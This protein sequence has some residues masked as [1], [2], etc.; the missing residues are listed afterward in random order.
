MSKIISRIIGDKKTIALE[1][2]CLATPFF[3]A[4]MAF[5]S[6]NS[7]T[8][9]LAVTIA[10]SGGGNTSGD[11]GSSATD[12]NYT[13]SEDITESVNNNTDS[14]LDQASYAG[15]YRDPNSGSLD[16]ITNS[17][18]FMSYAY[19]NSVSSLQQWYDPYTGSYVYDVSME[20]GFGLAQSFY[21]EFSSQSADCSNNF[22]P[23]DY[24]DDYNGFPFGDY[25]GSSFGD[26][27]G[28]DDS[29][30]NDENMGSSVNLKSGNLYHAQRVGPLAL[31]Y[32]SL[33]PHN[34]PL[35]TGW[36]H[37]FNLT[38]TANPDGSLILKRKDG[39]T[40]YF[41]QDSSGI[42]HADAK[43]GDTSSI[44]QNPHGSY[45]QTTKYGKVSTF[46][47]MGR[48]TSITDRNGNTTN[49][50]YNGTGLVGITDSTGRTVQFGVANGK[51]FSITDVAGMT[52]TISY[53]GD[54][55]SAIS[56]S[57]G[58]TWHYL[59][60]ANARM[61]RKTDPSGNVTSYTYDSATGMLTAST[62]PYGNVKSISYDTANGMAT[63]TQKDGGIWTR[64]YDPVLGAPLAVTD[65]YGNT[66]TYSYDSLR[67]LLS[68]AFPNGNTKSF[69]YDAAGN[70]TSAADALGNTTTM[71]YNAQNRVTGITDPLGNKR[72]FTYDQV[73]NLVSYTNPAGETT[74][75]QR[76]AKGNITNFTA[77]GNRTTQY[78]YD[79]YNHV[80]GVVDP[81][82]AATR[83]TRD[84][85]GNITG[86]TDA[87]GNTTQLLYD[88]INELVRVIDPLGDATTYTY[89]PNGNRA[90]KTDASGAATYYAY[91][92]NRRLTKLTDAL[93]GVTTFT[94]GSGGC[95]SCGAGA[96]K[97]ISITH[98]NGGVKNFAYDL[99]GRR[100]SKTDAVG[101]ST[102]YTY[103]ANGNPLTLTE[104]DGNTWQFAYDMKN[105]R[106]KA[107]DP[108]GIVTSYTYDAVGNRTS[109]TDG[110]GNVTLFEHNFR[111]QVT[112]I[113]DA[114]GNATT[115]AYGDP[116][117]GGG[118]G[119]L[120]S[121][122][123][124]DGNSIHFYYDLMGR[125][126]KVTDAL[127]NSVSYTYDANGNIISATDANGHTASF[128]HDVLN[129]VSKAVD[130]LKGVVN[131]GYTHTGKL[132]SVTDALGNVT[133]YNRDALGRATGVISPDA[134]TTVYAYN[135]DG[136]IK[137]R[138]DANGTTATFS[139]DLIGRLTG[140]QFPDSSQNISYAYDATG[141]QNGRGHLTGMTDPS[142]TVAFDY[143]KLGRVVNEVKAI[144]GVTYQTSYGYDAA[145]NLT[146]VTYPSGRTVAY[147][148]NAV[149]RP[150]DVAQLGPSGM[151]NL[152]SS[153]SYDKRGNMLN[154]ALGN[155]LTEKRSYDA[156]NLI[157][158]M[159]VPRVMRLNYL[160]D[161][162]KNI[163]AISDLLQAERSK[164]YA[165]DPL[166]RLASARGP[167]GIE[168]FA[169]DANGNRLSENINDASYA[170]SY[171]RNRLSGVSAERYVQ[172]Y[173]Y[174]QSGNPISDGALDYAYGQ[175]NRLS[176]VSVYGRIMAQYVYN[177][178]GQRVVKTSVR[179][180]DGDWDRDDCEG[181]YTV[182][183]YDL[184]GRL[185][186]ETSEKGDLMTDYIY[187]GRN[188]LAMVK[189]EGCREETYFYHN[190]HLGAPKV[191]PDEKQMPV[192]TADL[193][194]FG[195][196]EPHYEMASMRDDGRGGRI[197]CHEDF[198]NRITNNL[199]FPGQYFDE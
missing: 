15:F 4:L 114:L 38:I 105:E 196:N 167:W 131:L 70:M 132:A 40:I 188:P 72:A 144:L 161:P 1:L 33:D 92:Y 9:S 80:I 25:N 51:I 76:D 193:D 21:D 125:K 31:S 186:E 6:V 139:H 110:S 100:I 89:D 176:S 75:F 115:L 35:G 191:M 8:Q 126:A 127:G 148:F 185:I 112:K 27:N 56:D 16:V 98:P 88:T 108:Q 109:Q 45:T 26:Y 53:S 170:Y 124:P 71:T 32:N 123:D 147:T 91:N 12:G 172:N 49:L 43:S 78:V 86:R 19:W 178:K 84:V 198:H 99:L 165:Y 111:R 150:I 69:T 44:V 87:N 59:Y 153:I 154:L 134:G 3:I 39:N 7:V 34:G 62:D 41:S 24:W 145:G 66:T 180:R 135:P 94:Y 74:Q 90:S 73:G 58:N 122:T 106:T 57:M 141:S 179:D 199:R 17:R 82:G 79:R 190:D 130:P 136:T 183:H 189:K 52:Y 159:I 101:N 28:F 119:K 151:I 48:L 177:A 156:G 116:S 36:T 61:S 142:G 155:G 182:F 169:Y 117:A 140:V 50:S 168:S 121:I 42:F 157:S 30:S 103:D 164:A 77:P 2:I 143:D 171:E 192:W 102:S 113:T 138:T 166:N 85:A 55:L 152:A 23:I 47:P 173:Q 95:A 104:A 5:I 158:S 20:G 14:S 81:A 63:V 120:V 83:F 96:D 18:S 10:P 46:D 175:N 128:V 137:S 197:K 129:R 67:H 162:A 65:P 22:N 93:G 60:D 181:R 149:N 29:F 160:H 64:K 118:D 54:F 133:T 97:L 13:P 37:N 163:T 146:A 187:L 174:D 11:L 184:L 194:P 68:K 107:V 195:G